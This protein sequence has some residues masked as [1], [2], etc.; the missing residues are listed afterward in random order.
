MDG[1]DVLALFKQ[2][3]YYSFL[4]RDLSSLKNIRDFTY[5]TIAKNLSNWKVHKHLETSYQ[6]YILEFI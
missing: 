6:L 3:V 2:W 1:F 4:Y 5:F